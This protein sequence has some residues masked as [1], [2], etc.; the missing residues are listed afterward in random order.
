[1]KF[2]FIPSIFWQFLFYPFFWC[3]QI[4]M[5][6]P[7]HYLCSFII[8]LAVINL[9]HLVLFRSSSPSVFTMS[10]SSITASTYRESFPKLDLTPIIGVPTFESLHKMHREL[11]INAASVLQPS[12]WSQWSL[13]NDVFSRTLCVNFSCS[14]QTT[15][16]PWSF[17]TPCQ[18]SSSWCWS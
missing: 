16:T 14:F 7:F 17:S 4:S 6:L 10:P 8:R 15:R 5:L 2:E 3:W 11:K 12:E 18:C 1:M 13:R 9:I